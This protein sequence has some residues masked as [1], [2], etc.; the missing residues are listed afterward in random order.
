V[1]FHRTLFWEGVDAVVDKDRVAAILAHRLGCDTLL[2]LTDVDAVYRNWGTPRQ[3]PIR[4][5]SLAEAEALLATRELGVGSMRPKVEAAV[6]FVR[7]GGRRAVI[8]HLARGRDGLAGKAGTL[9]TGEHF[10]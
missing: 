10:T 8:T 6:Q 4:Q 5:L 1:Y 3:E 2:I 9:I 7:S